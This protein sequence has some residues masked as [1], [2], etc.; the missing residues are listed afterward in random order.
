MSGYGS[1]SSS[2]MGGSSGSMMS[3][4]GGGGA[5]PGALTGGPTVKPKKTLAQPIFFNA[6]TALVEHDALVKEYDAKLRES[7][8]FMLPR[9][10]PWY[11]SFEVQRVQVD[12]TKAD[13]KFEEK[14]WQKVT[15]GNQQLIMMKNWLPKYPQR[16][17]DVID[18]TAFDQALTMPIPPML[19]QDYRRFTK[20]PEID[21]IWDAGMANMP[22]PLP[23]PTTNLPD[24]SE[25]V[26]P[27][28]LPMAGGM[29]SSMGMGMGMGGSMGSAMESGSGYGMNYG[30][31][32]GGE[33]SGSMGA[34]YGGGME[35]SYGMGG[36]YGM[37]AAMI[38]TKYKMIRFYDR[39]KESDVR[40][41]FKYRVRV[42][43]EDPNYPSDKFPA[44]RSSD[45]QD[46]VFARVALLR[47]KED[48][49]AEAIRKANLA[50]RA[51]AKPQVYNR[52]KR[53]T[54]WS[55][56]S[57]SIYVRGTEDVYFGKFPKKGNDEVDGVLVKLD[58]QRGAYVP[59]FSFVTEDNKEDKKVP[60]IKRGAVLVYKELT[61]QFVHPITMVIKTW[62]KYSNFNGWSTV[63][64]IRGNDPLVLSEKDD[65]LTELGEVMVLMGDG[66]VEVTNEYDDAF[67]YRGF[68]FADERE[69]ADNS[70]GTDPMGA[71]SGYGTTP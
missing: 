12:P 28:D 33:M 69:A 5:A 11:L 34:G 7:A 22:M 71:M 21:W 52:T 2:M 59:M 68:T 10:R 8:S 4:S 57:N 19:I 42:M 24:P 20:H 61:T 1:E 67:W 65:P 31:G 27:G 50:L 32:S 35:S 9:D 40:K 25:G 60:T 45:L 47:Q 63:V 18:P 58:T 48:P 17:P 29:D 30:M 3:G 15:D 23:D 13:Q 70:S 6:V 39:L 43:L 56:P 54:P 16:V 14:D 26:L 53:F 66:R 62:E 36:G 44:P 41:T 38:P 37:G 46:D 55:E 49:E 51:N 64:D